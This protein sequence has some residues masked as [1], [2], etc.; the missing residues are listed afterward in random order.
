MNQ[1]SLASPRHNP[2]DNDGSGNRINALKI[3]E[4]NGAS[5]ALEWRGV[6]QG[7][8]RVSGEAARLFMTVVWHFVLALLS[9]F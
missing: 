5:L 1:Y 7:V 8:N 2:L 6:L 4:G 9:G 3:P